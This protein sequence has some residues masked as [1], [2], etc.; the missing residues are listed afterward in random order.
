MGG[1]ASDNDESA[2]TGINVTPFVDIA[3]VLL[4]IFMVIAPALKATFWV[5][6]PERANPNEPAPPPDPNPR[7]GK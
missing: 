6:V 1:G 4:I 5:R 3:L 7:D 2:I